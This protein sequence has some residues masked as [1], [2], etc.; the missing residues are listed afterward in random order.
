[1]IVYIIITYEKKEKQNYPDN[2]MRLKSLIRSLKFN[3]KNDKRAEKE[4][5]YEHI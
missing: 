3:Y 1:M 4:K 5:I 2:S